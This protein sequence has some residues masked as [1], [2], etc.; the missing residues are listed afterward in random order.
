M[1]TG[2]TSTLTLTEVETAIRAI[3]TTG[4]SYTRPGLSLT[5]SDLNSLRELRKT[6]IREAAKSS[7]EGMSSIPD[8]S[9]GSGV[10]SEADE[11]GAG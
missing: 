7:D 11:W 10:E 2:L 9:A 5:R 4:I 8:F 1:S 6:L 3:L